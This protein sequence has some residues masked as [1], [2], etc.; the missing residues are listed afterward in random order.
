MAA[1]RFLTTFLATVSI[2]LVGAPAHAQSETR[3]VVAGA[4]AELA[5]LATDPDGDPL[6]FTWNASG[7]R[8][9]GSG[10]RVTFDSTGLDP[11]SYEATV[12][13]SDSLCEV[14]KTFTIRVV[15]AGAATSI[16]IPA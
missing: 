8:I 2:V 3:E 16:A 13:V 11:G 14:S 1:R 4:T 10:P 9:V 12:T 15:A 7:G 5:V 6:T